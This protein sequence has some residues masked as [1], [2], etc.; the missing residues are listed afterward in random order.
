MDA[1]VAMLRSEVSFATMT[2]DLHQWSNKF[3][4]DTAEGLYQLMSCLILIYE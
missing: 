3:E 1:L 4:L 2:K